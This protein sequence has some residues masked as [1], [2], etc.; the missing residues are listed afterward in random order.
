MRIH[1]GRILTFAFGSHL[2]FSLLR[3]QNLIERVGQSD[4]WRLWRFSV[5]EIR[6]PF[7]PSVAE[8][9]ALDLLTTLYQGCFLLI[10][11]VNIDLTVA[12][13]MAAV[14]TGSL[15]LYFYR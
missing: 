9:P 12:S 7:A 11:S 15:I 8:P 13:Q 14:V 5:F 2:N 4:T 3:F 10:R 6:N 1:N